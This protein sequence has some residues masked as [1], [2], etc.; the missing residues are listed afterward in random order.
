MIDTLIRL[1]RRLTDALALLGAIGVVAMLIHI[2]VDV[3]LRQIVNVPIPATIEI[4]SRYYMV[5]VAYLALAWADR[6]GEMI[7]VEV[8]AAPLA[9]W[10][11]PNQVLVHLLCAAAFVVLTYTTWIEAMRQFHTGTY[12]MSLNVA[13]PVWPSYFVLPVSFALACLISLLKVA[14]ALAGRDADTAL[15]QPAP[16]SDTGETAR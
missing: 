3:V 1:A 8:F 5:M 13:V 15:R 10:R 4:V 7:S 11:R 12:V 6:R 16:H 2:T 14:V 9:R